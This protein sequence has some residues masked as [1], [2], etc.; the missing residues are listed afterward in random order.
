MRPRATG[1]YHD[2]VR[3]AKR[4]IL[5]RALRTAGGSVRRAAV[6]LE[7]E[8]TYAYVLIKELR[9]PRPARRRAKGE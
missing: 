8:R 7:L 5:A 3:R 2:L 6:A 4:D 1:H 9:V